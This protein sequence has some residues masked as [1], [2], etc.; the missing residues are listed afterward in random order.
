LDNILVTPHM[1]TA[2]EEALVEMS[3]VTEDIVRV[4][5]GEQPKYPVNR[6]D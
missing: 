3:L 1:C 5:A 2:T 6:L 4:L